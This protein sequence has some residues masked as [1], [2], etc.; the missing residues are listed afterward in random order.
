MTG[1][2]TSTIHGNSLTDDAWEG[3]LAGNARVTPT[4]D[5]TEIGGVGAVVWWWRELSQ[6]LPK[7]SSTNA[8]STRECTGQSAI[9]DV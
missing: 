8:V 5:L 4:A 9:G 1:R 2:D 7:L 6:L 3:G